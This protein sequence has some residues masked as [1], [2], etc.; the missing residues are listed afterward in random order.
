MY[1]EMHQ[2]YD[3]N[4]VILKGNMIRFI[5]QSNTQHPVLPC[6]AVG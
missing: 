1:M 3:I 2:L 6:D 5:I 4:S